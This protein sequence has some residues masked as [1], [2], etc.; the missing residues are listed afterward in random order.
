MSNKSNLQ[1]SSIQKVQEL[2]FGDKILEYKKEFIKTE[3]KIDNLEKSAQQDLDQTR[4]ELLD[5]IDS[6][7]QDIQGLEVSFMKDMKEKS[8]EFFELVEHKEKSVE[9]M[10]KLLSEDFIEKTTYLQKELKMTKDQNI[11]LLKE[12]EMKQIKVLNNV[13]NEYVSKDLLS[14]FLTGF[15]GKL[16]QGSIKDTEAKSLN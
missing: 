3:K 2:I 15:A 11:Q 10:I 1:E 16:N 5:F 7:K 6:L 12:L 4:G 8:R 14:Q 13:R 9:N